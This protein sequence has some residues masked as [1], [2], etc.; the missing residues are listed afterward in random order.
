MGGTSSGFNF[1]VSHHGKYVCIASH[2]S[3][4]I[5]VDI[6]DADTRS[7]LFSGAAAFIDVFSA[8]FTELEAR[9]ML[10]QPT[11]AL[12]YSHFYANWSLKE[13]YVKALGVG[14]ACD[15]RRVRLE[16]PPAD[17]EG[18]GRAALFL[19]G[20]PRDDW[21]CEFFRLDARHIVSVAR[22]AASPGEWGED[23][24]PLPQPQRKRLA[25]LLAALET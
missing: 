4:K 7:S 10:D 19:E 25:D 9:A 20:E 5:G 12:R 2:A 15:L 1:N 22:G 3:L 6:V 23:W 24:E 13:A 17:V 14:L 18:F 16:V 8:Q 11:E 21:R